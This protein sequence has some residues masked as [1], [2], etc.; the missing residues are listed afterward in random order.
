MLFALCS[1]LF[2][3]CSLLFA[4]RSLL[5]ALCSLLFAPTSSH[6]VQSAVQTGKAHIPLTYTRSQS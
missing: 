1:S 4:L 5:F 6:V 2:A 3:L